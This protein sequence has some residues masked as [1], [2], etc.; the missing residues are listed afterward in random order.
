M[1]ALIIKSIGHVIGYNFL[2]HRLHIMWQI[3]SAMN[4]I[5]VGNDVYIVRLADDEERDEGPCNIIDHHL[6]MR[7]WYHD[8]DPLNSVLNTLPFGFISLIF[9]LNILK[10]GLS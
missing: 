10:R 3:Q 4:F 6:A 1:K 9:P 2:V 5:D 7:Q 8:F